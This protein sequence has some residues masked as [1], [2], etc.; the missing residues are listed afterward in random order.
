MDH[1]EVLRLKAVEKYILGELSG[2]DR[3]RFEEHYF[4]CSECA[5][6]IR[7]LARIRSASRMILEGDAAAE[8]SSRQQRK[9]VSWFG[10]LK[11][12]VTVPAMVALAAIVIFQ[13]SVTIP[14]LK[15]RVAS[16]QTAQIYESS[17]RL[18]GATRGADVSQVAVP[19]NESFGLDFDFT[20]NA[21]FERYEGRLIDPTGKP[22]LTFPVR[23]EA[24]NK[25]LHVVVPAGIVRSEKYDLVFFGK[26]GATSSVSENKE[27]QRLSFVVEVRP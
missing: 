23:G 20:P 16:A 17:Y 12:A 2:E 18:Q 22:V 14:R 10:W 25:E 13:S 4:D 21:S 6:D 26:N 15:E 9:N 7:A 19:S 1:S 8:V 3:E 5:S 27:V 24:A 11:P